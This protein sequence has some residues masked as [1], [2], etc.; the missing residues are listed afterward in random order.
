MNNHSI[1]VV[2]DLVATKCC[3]RDAEVILLVEL[4]RLSVEST[5]NKEQSV[6]ICRQ[7]KARGIASSN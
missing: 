4:D 5:V 1:D 3:S 6:Q 7:D 2:A